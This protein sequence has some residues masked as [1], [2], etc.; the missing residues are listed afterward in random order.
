MMSHP[1]KGKE[2]AIYTLS[3]RPDRVGDFLFTTFEDALKFRDTAARRKYWPN[4][5]HILQVDA[6]ITDC[7]D[8]HEEGE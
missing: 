4:E 1:D 7:F 8:P 2:I 3:G 6:E 5:V